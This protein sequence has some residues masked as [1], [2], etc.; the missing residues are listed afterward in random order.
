MP[1]AVEQGAWQ[2]I[3]VSAVLEVVVPPSVAAVYFWALQVD[4]EAEGGVLAG[5]HTGLQ[6]NPRYPGNTAVNWGGYATA[7]YGGAVLPGTR[8][9]LPGFPDDPHTVAYSWKPRQRYRLRVFRSPE[10]VLGWRAEVFDLVSKEAAVIRDLD[11]ASLIPRAATTTYLRRPV[12]WSEVFAPCDAPSV[13]VC[14]SEL[15]AL[16]AEG[17][18]VRPEG[19]VV[20]YQREAA[21]GC[22]NTDVRLEDRGYLQTTNVARRTPQGSL[23]PPR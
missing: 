16:T 15:K 22:S 17:A 18:V 11:L 1:A 6:W 3:E 19:V 14:W 21:G 12:V 20:N 23:L 4:F 9:L 8:S 10:L 5:A 2:L 7:R 13:T